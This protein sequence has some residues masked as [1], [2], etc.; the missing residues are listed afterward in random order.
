M[1]S[2]VNSLRLTAVLLAVIGETGITATK[3]VAYL[4]QTISAKQLNTLVMAL[5]DLMTLGALTDNDPYNDAQC[6]GTY[7]G[8]M[9][10]DVWFSY[11]ACEKRFNDRKYM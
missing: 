9:H 11:I 4:Y 2:A 1:K 6:S 8:E 10:A 3:S 7:L 5:G